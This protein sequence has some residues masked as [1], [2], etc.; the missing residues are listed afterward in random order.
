MSDYHQYYINWGRYGPHGPQPRGMY[1]PGPDIMG[2]RGEW[3]GSGADG[4]Y[5]ADQSR[6]KTRPDGYFPFQSILEPDGRHAYNPRAPQY[7]QFRSGSYE[8]S[9]DWFF[10]TRFPAGWPVDVPFEMGVRR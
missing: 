6:M 8:P 1:L 9:Q 5:G 7:P 10:R 4:R 3:Y 2:H